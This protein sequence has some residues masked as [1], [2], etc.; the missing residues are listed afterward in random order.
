M[1]VILHGLAAACF[2]AVAA[3]NPGLA[4][5]WL[6]VAGL[7]LLPMVIYAHRLRALPAAAESEEDLR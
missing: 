5:A 6:A 1:L 3:T 7:Q 2:F 4:G